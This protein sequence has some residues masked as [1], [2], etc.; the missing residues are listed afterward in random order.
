M[1]IWSRLTGRGTKAGVWSDGGAFQ[2]ML[3][4]I[5]S[6]VTAK[7]GATVNR[8]TA[9]RVAVVFCCL[10]VLGEG[11]AQVPFKVMRAG[12]STVSR[13]PERFDA[14]DHPLYDL[15]HRAPNG[16]QTSFE[17]REQ[18]VMHAA[19]CG[20]AHVFKNMVNI[21]SRGPVVAELILLDPGRVKVVQNEDW[22]L[23]YKVTGAKSGE[24]KDFPQD[25]IWTVRGPS[26]DGV[27]GL[28]VLNIA[29]DAIGLSIS[30]EESHSKLHANGVQP[31]GTYSVDNTLDA[32]QYK[33]LKDWI[34]AEFV[35][36]KNSGI[37]MILGGGAK[38]VAQVMNGVDSQHLETRLHQITEICRFFRVLPLMV[39]HSDKTQTFASAE[40][41][42]LAH[43]VHTL[44][45]WYERIQQSADVNLL[46]KADRKAGYYTKLVEAGLLRGAMKDTAEYLARLTMGGIM[47]RNEA[48]GKLDLN[49]I[50]GLDEPLTP[51]NMTTDPTGA[52]APTAGA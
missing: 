5:L 14:T 41:M 3:G 11:V 15:L 8:Q 24:V 42:F 36:A 45:P 44:M 25:A 23:T 21:G 52:P 40:Q 27:L 49:P 37:P 46:S 20:R 51:T 38:W 26:W 2:D 7:S 17:F 43:V 4:A 31:S 32:K 29:R 16:W 39:G 10:R 19:L 12:R 35:G 33:Q 22:S 28:D 18:M 50:E 47:E 9:F 13:H 48:R 30:T 1:S 34:T 6:G